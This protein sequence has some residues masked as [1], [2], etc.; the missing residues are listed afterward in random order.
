MAVVRGL[1]VVEEDDTDSGDGR[2][3]MRVLAGGGTVTVEGGSVS[4][5]VMVSTS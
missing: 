1:G 2:A 3:A 4:V 5:T